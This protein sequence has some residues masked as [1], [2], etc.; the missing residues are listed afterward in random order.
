MVVATT[1]RAP[2][3][4]VPQAGLYV[5]PVE[6]L[7]TRQDKE[8]TG[9][10]LRRAIETLEGLS[11]QGPLEQ[12]SLDLGP[13]LRI[14]LVNRFRAEL[15]ALA[16]VGVAFERGLHRAQH[17]LL[18]ETRS[19]M[20]HAAVRY[21][22]LNDL[23][24]TVLQHGILGMA[25]VYRQTHADK[26]AAWGPADAEWFR[27]N[28]D[29]PVRIEATG[30][31]RFDALTKD[32]STAPNRRLPRI[33]SRSRVVLFA[34]QP[35][36]QHSALASPWTRSRVLHMVLE[37]ARQSGDYVLIV[38]WHP[39]EKG[40]DLS[41]WTGDAKDTIVQAHQ[42]NIWA[43]V[44]RSQVVLTLSSTVALE[45]M[46]L[47]RP[48]VFLGPADPESPF[49]PP[50]D[51]AGLRARSGEELTRLIGRLLEDASFREEVFKGQRAYL[52]RMY[53]PLDGQAADRV[54]RLLQSG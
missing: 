14:H 4:A 43:L 1:L 48:I 42:E 17:L 54:V 31:P 27:T 35:F 36:V 29:G 7:L 10:F 32:G 18:V 53:T 44:R 40:D 37:A 15:N 25:R 28:L 51:G 30:S 12:R 9:T 19:P 50:E 38:K 47:D 34:S 22:R 3:R 8:M 41:S 39:S 13:V 2:I 52:E 21:A 23:S 11:L 5:L 33:P 49:H 26:I 20:A 16:T 24:V 45:G 6:M 46:F